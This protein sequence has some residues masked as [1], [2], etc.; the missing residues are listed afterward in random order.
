[1]TCALPIYSLTH[2]LISSKFI[3][4]PE[5]VPLTFEFSQQFTE[6]VVELICPAWVSPNMHQQDESVKSGRVPCLIIH[7]RFIDHIRTPVSCAHLGVGV[8]CCRQCAG[9]KIYQVQIHFSR[10]LSDRS[11]VPFVRR[12]KIFRVLFAYPETFHPLVIFSKV[13]FKR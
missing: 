8:I 10:P 6:P 13:L 12:K 5:R 9:R 4:P 2:S 11:V 3:D 7:D 1:Q